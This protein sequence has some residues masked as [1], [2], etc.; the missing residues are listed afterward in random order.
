ML[1][2]LQ[3]SQRAT[4]FSRVYVLTA[5]LEV[6]D[7][8]RR[9]IAEHGFGHQRIYTAPA[10]DE[11]AQ[12]AEAAYQQQR[13]LSVWRQDQTPK[14]LWHNLRAV[15]L[16]IRAHTTFNLRVDD[17]LVDGA[18]IQSHDLPELL[19]AEVALVQ[20]TDILKNLVDRAATFEAERETVL[21]PGDD[22]EE[23][24]APPATW[25]DFTRR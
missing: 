9:I 6:D 4:W 5:T 20:A 12:R 7:N 18:V 22:D 25:P 24:L 14:I 3:R 8:E 16:A 15:T 11:L 2:H 1:L 13:K 23:K 21:M 19:R 10:A 17:L